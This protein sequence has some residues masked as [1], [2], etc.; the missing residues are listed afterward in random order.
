MLHRVAEEKRPIDHRVIE[1]MRVRLVFQQRLAVDPEELEAHA[2]THAE[3][4]V[5]SGMGRTIRETDQR[6]MPAGPRVDAL[7]VLGGKPSQYF[8]LRSCQSIARG[9]G[10]ADN[11]IYA[12]AFG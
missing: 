7:C 6:L 4:S 10:I 9:M 2:K 8:H 5:C 12:L 11:L 3:S 1:G